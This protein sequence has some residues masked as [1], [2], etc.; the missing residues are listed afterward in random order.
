MAYLETETDFR[1][2]SQRHLKD[3]VELLEQPTSDASAPDAS[4]RHLVGAM[5]LA[6]YAVECKLKEFLF[7]RF[8]PQVIPASGIGVTLEDIRPH[9]NHAL[10]SVLKNLHSIPDLWTATGLSARDTIMTANAGT[11]AGWQVAWRY[12]PPG[13][14]TR[15]DAEQLV[16]AASDLV[17]WIAAQTP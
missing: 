1:L 15:A 10:G 5:Y 8:G 9:I 4:I 11:C 12:T 3:A 13:N 14:R 2:A 17:T 6:G 7:R 16:N